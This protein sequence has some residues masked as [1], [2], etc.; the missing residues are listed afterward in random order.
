MGLY[1]WIPLLHEEYTL[2]PME[3]F[4]NVFSDKKMFVI[5]VKGLEP[6]TRCVKDHNATTVP[7]DTCETY[8]L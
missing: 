2:K 8:D 3:L 1:C 5:T 6:D 7:T 4:L